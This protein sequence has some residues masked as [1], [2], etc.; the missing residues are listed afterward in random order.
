MDP[1][2]APCIARSHA[3]RLADATGQTVSDWRVSHVKDAVDATQIRTGN[4]GA[5]AQ[6]DAFG[7]DGIPG[8][9]VY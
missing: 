1:E 5:R 3:T 8:S 6:Q 7:C 2:A 9:C 4:A